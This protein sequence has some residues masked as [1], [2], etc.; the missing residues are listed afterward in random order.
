MKVSELKPQYVELM[1]KVLE[2]GV[3]Y[4]SQKYATAVHKCCCGCG[5]KVVTPL[6]PTEW[7][8]SVT[9]GAVTLYPSIGNW[10]FGCRSHYWIRNNRVVWAGDMANVEIERNRRRDRT[11][12]QEYF[13]QVNAQRNQAPCSSTE[14]WLPRVWRRFL[15]WLTSR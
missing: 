6:K 15:N 10:S 8:L 4:I 3:L 12:K 9:Q 13:A 5:E 1:P 14:K 7:S 11:A 2:G